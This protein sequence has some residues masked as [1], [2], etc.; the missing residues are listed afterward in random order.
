MGCPKFSTKLDYQFLKQKNF[1][2]QKWLHLDRENEA[3]KSLALVVVM[4]SEYVLCTFVQSLQ[5]PR[6]MTYKSLGMNV[7]PTRLDVD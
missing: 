3:K 5:P 2:R 6:L 7:L 1:T 4:T